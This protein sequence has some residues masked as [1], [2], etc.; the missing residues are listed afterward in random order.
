MCVC[1][2]VCVC[3]CVCGL[4]SREG[5]KHKLKCKDKMLTNSAID[6]QK[7]IEQADSP[8]FFIV[9]NEHKSELTSG[10]E[11]HSTQ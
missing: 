11:F 4:N 10:P 1:L 6:I 5:E 7:V 2:C 8:P 9:Q 3:V